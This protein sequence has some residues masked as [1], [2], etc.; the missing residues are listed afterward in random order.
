MIETVCGSGGVLVNP[1]QLMHGIQAL[2]KKYGFCLILDEVM[3]GMGRCG[4]MF[5]F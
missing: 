4:E 1:P 2:C 3:A 5:A